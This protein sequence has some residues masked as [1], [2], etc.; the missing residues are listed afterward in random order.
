MECGQ[1]WKLFSS[2][3]PPALKNEGNRAPVITVHQGGGKQ[4]EVKYISFGEIML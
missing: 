3:N 1:E 4:I 2:V